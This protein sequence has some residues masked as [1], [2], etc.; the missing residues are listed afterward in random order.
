MGF[1]HGFWERK[2]AESEGRENYEELHG[3]ERDAPSESEVSGRNVLYNDVQRDGDGAR[4]VIDDDIAVG[5]F[6]E[7]GKGARRMQISASRDV[8]CPGKDQSEAVPWLGVVVLVC[9]RQRQG[10]L[11]DRSSSEISLS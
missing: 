11:E 8:A 5:W 9:A 6:T 3:V 7:T 1:Y 4:E 2:C 10:K